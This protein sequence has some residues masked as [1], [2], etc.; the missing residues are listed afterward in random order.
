MNRTLQSDAEL[1]QGSL[2]GDKNAFSEI[3]R[4]YQ[5]LICSITYNSVGNLAASEDLAQ[6]VFLAAWGKLNAVRQPEKICSWLTS[7]ARN[8]CINAARK[9]MKNVT[10][11]AA[12]LEFAQNIVSNAAAPDEGVI[13][14]EQQRLLWQAIEHIPDLYRE[15][16][17][18]FY[19]RQRSVKDVAQQLEL[20]EDT[21]KTRLSRG[22]KMLREH[23]IEFVEH[24]LGRTKP[25]PA[26]ATAII[27][28]LPVITSK[29]AA[30]GVVAT[31]GGAAAK[32]T[33]AVVT[34]GAAGLV[35]GIIG[36]IL[37]TLG[38]VFGAWMSIK[39]TNSPRERRF[40][41]R[42]N[43]LV[44]L[45]LL[46][47]VGLPLGLALADIIPQ[48]AYL[49]PFGLFFA[50]LLPLIYWGNK[51]QLEIQKQDGTYIE[52]KSVVSPRPSAIKANIIGCFVGVTC[53][54]VW[55][56]CETINRGYYRYTS[57]AITSAVILCITCIMASIKNP[58]KFR[59][60]AVIHVIVVAIANIIAIIALWPVESF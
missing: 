13:D 10:D 22:R 35:G 55:L 50:I 16:L 32:G 23:M 28:S 45:L 26:F 29:A 48:W 2:A 4:R 11:G 33:T 24:T 36:S 52:P 42:M 17:I 60:I 5:A 40:M 8:I 47:L 59:K 37:G 38:G 43:V 53:S 44:F 3:V 57:L 30:A 7:I 46:L 51:R 54:L 14:Q 27:A 1:V 41:I 25:G 19:R 18:L 56:V 49:A 20:S 9:R 15:P 39:N 6:E 31:T 34:G 58:V 21:V 12:Q